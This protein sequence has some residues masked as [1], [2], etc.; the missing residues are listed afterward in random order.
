[1]TKKPR[2]AIY[3]RVSTR[4]QNLLTQF[5][6][7]RRE[8]EHRGWT[9]VRVYRDRR[10]GKNAKRPGLQAMLKEAQR[11]RFD[12]VA[13]WTPSRLGRN[14]NDSMKIMAELGEIEVD[15]FSIS[16]SVDTTDK[17]GRAF[18]RVLA[19]FAEMQREE[20]VENVNSGLDRARAQGK[21]LGRPRLDDPDITKNVLTKR[22]EGIGIK[23]IARDI[24]ISIGKV[25]EILKRKEKKPA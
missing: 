3:L 2:V 8:A 11:R 24:G 16:P 20:I 7:L 19:I 18:F 1:M 17:M 14:F 21:K 15:L 9:I 12:I 23:R 6:R 25:Y 22:K 10:T 4:K 13:V 5:I